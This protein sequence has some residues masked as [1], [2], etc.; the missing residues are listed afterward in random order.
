MAAAGVHC[1]RSPQ[2]VPSMLDYFARLVPVYRDECLACP[3]VALCGGGCLY[4]AMARTGSLTGVKEER[5]S[6]ERAFLQWLVGLITDSLRSDRLPGPLSSVELAAFL[7]P[8]ILD[9]ARM[10]Q[11]EGM[12][13]GELR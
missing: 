7:P 12:L 6:Y 5:C 8:G 13:G 2:D 10:P 4:D 1:A 9:R 11:P 3:C